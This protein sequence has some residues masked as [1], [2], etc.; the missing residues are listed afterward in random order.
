M[1]TRTRVRWS[2]QDKERGLLALVLNGGS[3][4]HA[5]RDLAAGGMKVSRKTIQRWRDTMPDRLEA[6]RRDVAPRVAE[7]IAA[8]AEAL[9]IQLAE[10]ER[11]ALELL[12]G[13]LP[14]MKPSE[15]AGTLRNLSVSKSLQLDKASSPLRGRPNVRVEHTGD[16]NDHL[17]A[18]QQRFPW[19]VVDGDAE[20]LPNPPQIGEA[21]DAPPPSPPGGTSTDP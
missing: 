5:M 3:P 18:L 9:A 20:E 21:G 16:A 10:A 1:T 8:E 11:E 6:I 17:R 2:H 4:T 12:R 19:L 15:L 13:R 7:K 14:D